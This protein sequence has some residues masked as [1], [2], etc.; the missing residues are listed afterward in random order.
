[1]NEDMGFVTLMIYT[2][3]KNE[4]DLVKPLVREARGENVE[5]VL[6]GQRRRRIP[7]DVL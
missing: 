4:S 2:T 7:D 5:E 3:N 1:M 6:M